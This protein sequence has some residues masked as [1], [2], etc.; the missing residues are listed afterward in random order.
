MP[1]IKIVDCEPGFLKRLVEGTDE[2]YC[3][4]SFFVQDAIREKIGRH[5][6]IPVYKR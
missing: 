5:S 3:L 2:E 1:I 4:E 6:T